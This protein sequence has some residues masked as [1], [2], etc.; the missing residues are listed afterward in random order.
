MNKLKFWIRNLF[1]MLLLIIINVNCFVIFGIITLILFVGYISF[2]I[3]NFIYFILPM[4]W[5]LILYSLVLSFIVNINYY[6]NYLKKRFDKKCL[7]N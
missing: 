2:S 5:I 4:L 1:Q 6:F 3:P 7:K